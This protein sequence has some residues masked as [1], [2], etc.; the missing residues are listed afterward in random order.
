VDR[1]TIIA[2]A[3]KILNTSG[4]L[5]WPLAVLAVIV[6]VLLMAAIE[7]GIRDHII[8]GPDSLFFPTT[9]SP[10]PKLSPPIP[11]IG[12][13]A[14]QSGYIPVPGPKDDGSRQP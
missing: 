8:F 14:E 7:A 5:P 9:P 13:T 11:T 10:D 1:D 4:L 6:L 3:V 12:G 2:E